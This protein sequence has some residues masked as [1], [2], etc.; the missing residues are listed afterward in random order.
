[1]YLFRYS[2]YIT[3]TWE[4][5]RTFSKLGRKDDGPCMLSLTWKGQVP[6][7]LGIRRPHFPVST[8]F[9]HC[10]CFHHTIHST[11]YHTKDSRFPS[12]A[13]S[14]FLFA[15]SY[16]NNETPILASE[17]HILPV[18]ATLRFARVRCRRRPTQLTLIAAHSPAHF[19]STRAHRLVFAVMADYSVLKVPELKKLLQEKQLQVTGN[20]ADLIARLQEHDKANEAP[21]PAAPGSYISVA[22]AYSRRGSN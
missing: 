20:K 12:I 3:C 2:T 21:K 13:T 15:S 22:I 4:P 7:K 18:F 5:V 17:K 10:S 6:L 1:M 16:Y 19:N 11:T 8:R 9:L 14:P